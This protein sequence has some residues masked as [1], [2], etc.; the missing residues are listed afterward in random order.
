MEP[1]ATVKRALVGAVAR[2][3]LTST[4]YVAYGYRLASTSSAGQYFLGHVKA[5]R[6]LLGHESL[7]GSPL[8]SQGGRAGAGPRVARGRAL[9]EGARGHPKLQTCHRAGGVPRDSVE[10]G[11]DVRG[12]RPQARVSAS[13]GV[14]H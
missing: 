11:V 8:A 5:P 14:R 10:V 1:R 2:A 6:Q 13:H 3:V 9:Q 7:P 12:G 4:P